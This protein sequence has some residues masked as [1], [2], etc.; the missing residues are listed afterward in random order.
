MI[1]VTAPFYCQLCCSFFASVSDAQQHLLGA[2]HNE[3]FHEV[4]CCFSY[5][6]FEDCCV[7][8]CEL[9]SCVSM[10][11]TILSYQCCLSI[12]PYVC[13]SDTL[14]FCI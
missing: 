14:W 4:C 10:Q 3:K 6:F 1:A 12:R 5:S 2:K 9:L 7:H 8:I 11:S 13:P